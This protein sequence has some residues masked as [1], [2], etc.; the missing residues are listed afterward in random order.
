MLPPLGSGRLG[1]LRIRYLL[2]AA[3][4]GI[5]TWNLVLRGRLLFQHRT[6]IGGVEHNVIHGIQKILLGEV[7]YE[8][9][10][11]LP[12][13]VIQY[14]PGYYLL[15]A[16]V[17]GSLGLH[18]DEARDIYLLSRAISLVLWMLTGALVFGAC[19]VAGAEAWSSFLA[20]VITLCSTWEQSFSRMDA[21]VLAITAGTVL[22]FLRWIDHGRTRHLVITGVLGVLAMFTKQS[23]VVIAA[24]PA[25]YLLLTASWKALRTVLLTQLITIAICAGITLLLGTPDAIYKNIVL[26]LRN[27][28]SW[29]MYADLFEPATYKYFVGWHLLAIYTIV[30]GWRSGYAPSRFLAVVVPMSLAF[31][32]ITGLKYGS[33]LN[34][35]HES[36]MLTFIATAILLPRMRPTAHGTLIGWAF[37]LY[38]CLFAAYRT[39]SVAAWWR[40]GEPDALHEERLKDDLIVRSVLEND[41]DLQPDEWVYITYRDHLEHF[42]VGRSLLTQKDIV[43]YSRERL[44]D[45]RA[46]HRAMSDGTVRFVITEAPSGPVTVLDSTYTDWVP[47]RVVNGRTILAR[48]TNP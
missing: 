37:A 48:S 13:D 1:R 31:A 18:G 15:C 30:W 23:G 27:G 10:E 20:A 16:T 47:I 38:G 34:Y 44:F 11:R 46:F 45:Y 39:N 29:M 32:M 28:F 36:L 40:V 8:D 9:P 17:G 5:L 19:R 26:G 41:L 3:L 42:L 7:L 24:A 21:L 6:D 33:R 25:A 14:T 12:F 4:L 2:Y 43:Q 22:V 35:V